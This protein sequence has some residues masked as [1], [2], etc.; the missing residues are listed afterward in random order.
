MKILVLGA[1]G[2]V[3]D[4]FV[5]SENSYEIIATYSNN[6]IQNDS[7]SSFKINLPQDWLK[8]KKLILK[9]K[10]EVVLNTMAYSNVDFCE[11]NKEEVYELHVGITEKIVR[12]CTQINAK[13][14]FLSTDYVFDGKIGNYTEE[15]KPNPVNFYGKTKEEAEKIVLKNSK[16]LVIRTSLIY[17]SSD[18][19]R[20]LK[21]VVNS[22][23]DG[24]EIDAY[25]DIFNSATLVD[26]L[27]NA[28]LRSIEE[29]VNGIFHVV[30]SSCVSRYEFAKMIAKVFDLN[31][32]LIKSTSIKNF[33]LDATRPIKPCLD[34]S[35]ASKIL[36]MNFSTI[37]EGI[38]YVFEQKLDVD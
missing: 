17:G 36:G 31:E 13:M 23:K 25:D 10:P 38:K 8:F 5:H 1:S 12:L 29:D 28:I 7:F 27:V 37:E 32:S 21:F 26:E 6:K 33:E 14:I 16:N 9:E 3:G 22:L 11:N 34:N 2:L 15:D 24:K 35:K 20:F 19:V 4:A 30:G 18:K